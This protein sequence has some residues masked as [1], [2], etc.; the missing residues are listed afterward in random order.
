LKINEIDQSV[1]LSSEAPKN[2]K[3]KKDE[4][5]SAPVEIPKSPEVLAAEK[6]IKKFANQFSE[7]I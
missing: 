7:M 2:A 3:G 1:I 6:K 4:P 5:V